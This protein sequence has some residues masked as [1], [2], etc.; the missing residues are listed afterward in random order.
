MQIPTIDPEEPFEELIIPDDYRIIG[1]LNTADKHYLHSL[2]DAL[3]RRFSIIEIPIP[4]YEQ[5]DKELY[6]VISKATDKLDTKINL[7]LS[8]DHGTFV[9]GKGDPDAENI[10]DTLYTLMSFIR[11][12]KPLGTALLISMLRFMIVNHSLE[13]VKNKEWNSSLDSALVTSI[14]PQIE[15]L[16]YWTL[17]VIR[18][19]LC[20]NLEFFFENDPEIKDDGHEKYKKDFR[21]SVNFLRKIKGEKRNKII[22]KFI[23]GKLGTNK[24]K[25]KDGT[26]LPDKDIE[27]LKIWNAQNVGKKP[28]LP[29]FRNAIDQIISE[30]GIDEEIEE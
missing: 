2:S 27:Y 11:E 30:K 14:I 25:K 26:E 4:D 23:E 20:E 15:D 5:K 13:L 22:K 9:R 8:H 17:K 12:I 1:T 18:A 28:N 19:A 24:E 16:N 3:K 21:K 6:F 7:E 29:K 10:V